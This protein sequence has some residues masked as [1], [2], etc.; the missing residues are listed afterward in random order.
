MK[1]RTFV[2][3][4]IATGIS[5]GSGT[6]ALAQEKAGTATPAEGETMTQTAV[7]SGYAP[8]NGLQMYYEIHGSGGVPLVLL[9]GGLMTIGLLGDLVPRLAETR[10]VVAVE[11][12]GHGHTADIDRPLRMESLT[13]DVAALIEQ[14]DLGQPDVFGDSMGGGTALQLAIRRPDLVR[15]AV[16]ASTAFAT[17]GWHPDIL[18][19]TAMM[20]ADAA[21]QMHETAFYQAYVSVAPRPEDWPVL[22]TKV[23]KMVRTDGGP[24]AYDWTE[25]VKSVKAPTLLIVGDA[26]SLLPE[27]TEAL[28]RLLGGRVVGDLQPLPS[29]QLAV[30]PGTGHTE[31]MGRVDLLLAIVPPF[32]DAPLPQ[33]GS[34]P[35]QS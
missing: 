17:S 7:K 29:A 33:A 25:G 18:A 2:A 27:H 12:Q 34:E 35:A 23:G 24:S 14:L 4:T 19:A 11:L 5:L 26:D 1:R 20:N 9:H 8:V 13:D 6:A 3:G 21:A 30:L 10:Q 32:L 15:K 31:L 16:L 28:F 22:V